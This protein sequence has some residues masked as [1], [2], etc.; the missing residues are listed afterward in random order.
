MMSRR[1]NICGGQ[2]LLRAVILF[3]VWGGLAGTAIAKDE[4]SPRLAVLES[5]LDSNAADLNNAKE[6]LGDS[7]QAREYLESIL[8][9]QKEVEGWISGKVLPYGKTYDSLFGWVHSDGRIRDGIDGSIVSYSHPGPRRTILYA[10]K[11]CRIN[12][13]GD[14]YTHCD[15]VNDGETWQEVLAAHL[16][17]P[18]RNFGIT[19][20]S[21]YQAF[22]RMKKEEIRTPAKYIIFNIYE[23]DHYRNL[24]SWAN[25]R[26]GEVAGTRSGLSYPTLPHVRVNPSTGEFVEFSNPCPTRQSVYSLCDPGWVHETFNDDFVLKIMLARKNIREGKPENSYVEMTDLARQHG[27]EAPINSSETLRQAVDTLHTRAGL[28][29]TM[30]I[31]EKIEEYAAAHEKKVLYVLSF[32]TH[33]VATTIQ[34]E[35]RF[36]HKIV[37]FLK[38]NN[39]PFVDLLEAHLADFSTL[40]MSLENYLEHY[41]IS[42]YNPRGN[43]FTAFS[44]KDKLAE[45]LEPKPIPYDTDSSLYV[46]P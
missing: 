18:I 6:I 40:N 30:R 46:D 3:V 45:M 35:R 17:E 23:D 10:D 44:L 5:Q 24:D 12:T 27:I 29:A 22:L 20:F 34:G 11:S 43:F 16:C 25:I 2:A 41:W 38:G 19:G 1:L 33:T 15:Q 32:G 36:D 37:D 28:F 8:Y 42:H 31:V 14:S 26:A 13:Y 39:L 21:V 9:A 4:N 7:E